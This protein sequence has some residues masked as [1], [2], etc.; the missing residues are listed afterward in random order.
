MK[1]ALSL[2]RQ[3]LTLAEVI[4]LLQPCSHPDAQDMDLWRLSCRSQWLFLA[5][6]LC[7][8]VLSGAV[9]K[10]YLWVRLLPHACAV[11]RFQS[12]CSLPILPQTIEASSKQVEQK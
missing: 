4:V 10:V 1:P 8:V 12:I 5:V 7:N 2:G 9:L 6:L 11:S 3:N